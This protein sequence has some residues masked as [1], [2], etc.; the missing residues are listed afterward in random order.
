MTRAKDDGF[1]AV[2][3]DALGDESMKVRS[4]TYDGEW[5][6]F[7][8]AAEGFLGAVPERVGGWSAR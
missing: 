5:K 2:V 4:T 7:K 1:A 8:I 3:D 6:F